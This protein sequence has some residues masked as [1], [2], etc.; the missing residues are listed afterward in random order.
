M[1]HPIRVARRCILFLLFFTTS[2]MLRAQSPVASFTASSDSGCAPLLVNFINTS[3]GA[4]SYL[5]RFGN[6]N[7]STLSQPSSSYTGPGSYTVT[8]VAIAA[9]GQRDSVSRV[10]TVLGNPLADFSA[11]SPTN[12]DDY[13]VFAFTNLSTGAVSFL[14]D[15]G[16]GSGSSLAS[17]THTYSAPGSY[18]VKLIATNSFGC[19]DI[20]IRNSLIT[21]LPNPLATIGVNQSSTCDVNTVFQFSGSSANAASWLWNFGDGNTSALQNPS[22]QYSTPGTYPVTL[23][24]TSAGGCSDTVQAQNQISIG[25]SLVPSFTVSDSA[26]CAP[27]GV[28]F[29]CTVGNATSWLWDFG[30]GSTSTSDNPFHT[31]VNPGAY[32]VTLTVT[33][34]SGC[35]GS[36]TV[37]ALITADARPLANFT[38]VQ[39]SGCSPFTPQFIN[40]S[41][42]ATNY[43]WQ[44]STGDTSPAFLPGITLNTSGQIDVTLTAI[45]A[46]GC[47]DSL[48]RIRLLRVFNPSAN[49]SGFPL[50]GCPGMNVQFNYPGSVPLTTSYLWNF[51][52]GNT[53]TLPNP[54]HTYTAIGNYTVSLIIT[55]IFG[56]RDT[57]IQP[58]YVQV[59]NGQIAFGP[60]DTIRVCL[61]DPHSL[62][63]PTTGSNSWQ[64]S[65]GNGSGSAAQSPSVLYTDTG[66]YIVTLQTAMPGGCTQSFSPFA[67]VRV[68]PYDPK[69]IEINYLG[70][71]K[72]YVV[73]FSTQ[74]PD[75]TNYLWSFGDGNTSTLPNPTHTYAQ[76]GTYP[77]SLTLT[78][79]EGCFTTMDTTITLG[80][81]NPASASSHDACKNTPISFMVNNLTAFVSA[82][83]LFGDGQSGSGF[84]PTHS[85]ADSGTYIVQLI[86]TDVLGCIDTLTLQPS[87]L[88]SDPIPQ[89]NL[90]PTL[91]L[92]DTLYIQNQSAQAVSFIWHFGDGSTST[93]VNPRHQY[94]ATGYYTIRLEAIQNGCSV[95][96]TRDSA[97]LV[98]Q[99]V[100]D[101]SYTT[102]GLCMPLLVNF[103]YQSSGAVQWNWIFGDGDSSS[104]QNPSHL[105]TNDLND[106]LRLIVSDG[107][108]CRDTSAQVA[109]PYYRAAA[110][111]SQTTGC[112]PMQVQFSDNS[113]GA[114]SWL[115]D[116]GNGSTS[117]QQNPV[118][119]YT[120]GGLYDVMLIATFPGG[121]VDTIVYPQM[122]SAS[123][124]LANFFSPTNAGCSPTQISFQNTSNDAVQFEW[125]FGDGGSST[126]VNPQHIYYIPGTYSVT[127]IAT[128][129]FGCTDTLIRPDYISIPGTYTYFSLPSLDGCQGA[130]IG[131]TDS[132][133]NASSWNWDF[134]DGILD[135]LQNPLHVY[136]DTGTYFISLITSD[137]L[138]CTSSFT[139]PQPIR[140]HPKPQAFATVSDTSGC[141]SF[142]TSF[143][144]LSQGA[145][146]YFWWLGN[147]QT[148]QQDNPVHTY[149]Q[150]GL[151]YPQLEATSSFGC[152]DTF[153]FPTAVNVLSTPVAEITASDTIGCTPSVIS[154]SSQLSS[155]QNPSYLWHSGS[156]QSGT[157]ANF[158]ATYTLDSIYVVSLIITNDNGCSDTDSVAITVQP[159]PSALFAPDVSRGCTPLQV[160][161]SPADT[162]AVSYSW[163]FGQGQNSAQQAPAAVYDS[164]G[165]YPVTLWVE[166]TFG[167]R[168]TYQLSPGIEA[169]Q[170]PVA[171]FTSDKIQ[172]CFGDQV[173]FINQSTGLIQATWQWVI[174]NQTSTSQNAVYNATGQGFIH[175]SLVALNNNGCSDTISRIDYLEVFD[176]LPPPASPIRAVSVIDDN[177]IRITWAN[178]SDNDIVEYALYRFNP[179]SGNWI[180]IYSDTMP[181]LAPGSQLSNW[182][183]SGLNTL[184]N[185]YTYKLETVDYCGYKTAFSDLVAHTSIELKAK[186]NGLQIQLEWSPYRG[187]DVAGYELYRRERPGGQPLLIAMIDSATLSYT[188][189]T[190]QCPLEY[191]YRVKALSLCSLPFEAWSDTAAAWP[192]NIFEGQKSEIVRTTVMD[193]RTTLT[194]WLPPAVLP[195][196]VLEYRIL[197]SSDGINFSVIATVGAGTLSYNDTDVD[198]NEN[199]YT[200][201]VLVINDCGLP[202]G[203]RNIGKSILLQGERQ[204]RTTTLKW[205]KYEE[206]DSGVDYYEIEYLLPSGIW[207]KIRRVN[208][209]QTAVEI[210]D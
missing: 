88:I 6:G 62:S 38:V 162:T 135:T 148:S 207:Q 105:Y 124:P 98:T 143:I 54:S 18:T 127:L 30:D 163:D 206:W 152:K 130:A 204:P 22:H 131:F 118:Y 35:N 121:C 139:Y 164:A 67:I 75:V 186:A 150:S 89:F 158:S 76:A 33:T 156:G 36:V 137:S 149:L 101:F 87:I 81:P 79:G 32:S 102:S 182:T 165:I 112:T 200:Y 90:L 161:F 57:V 173:N 120:S 17:P 16:D 167:C 108:G 172:A 113:N 146:S 85:Y 14:W 198:V 201:R 19:Q 190:L 82:S 72:P 99:P 115:W 53:S 155:F 40:A 1:P 43:F 47:R 70:S 45:S 86:T 126:Q 141:N 44:F 140:I 178:G 144:N 106:S 129:S 194:E 133:V 114:L 2:L 116:F 80:Y 177:S 58:G 52:D 27:H 20:E 117:V 180:K 8:L 77:I 34:Q 154:F 94:S 29:D 147:G 192:E 175:A 107:Y 59:I 97:V 37:P 12:C 68:I 195:E 46:N 122:I 174:G 63:D 56:C 64:W 13:N 109:F 15:F 73:S 132:S 66:T 111:V 187:C 170:T 197:R 202:G 50:T 9:S 92:Y 196:R 123:Q 151:F 119:T 39:D 104:Q 71:C 4:V 93:T 191:E 49:F 83:W 21:I 166:N 168:D 31:Y 100:A 205:T 136:N 91:C 159:S 74:T 183:D 138:G 209:Q 3:T 203:E 169:L 42:G 24:V 142:T 184:Q 171:N 179:A 145:I 185:T 60:P 10:I 110:T 7:I 78:I 125:H 134:G 208:G 51:G 26:G 128:N 103:L 25:N 95:S 41:T 160:Q 5:W 48:R 28:Q 199:S 181:A 157:S 11:S 153:T 210:D 188:D 176:T 84:N 193:N 69:P 96:L 23:I 61:G 189:T 65:F 55:N